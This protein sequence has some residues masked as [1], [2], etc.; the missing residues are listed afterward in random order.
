[1]AKEDAPSGLLSKMAKFVRN[2]STNW[3]DL[4]EKES[5]REN[6]AYTKQALKEMIERKRRNDF[7][8]KREFDMLRKLRRREALGVPGNSDASNRP[9]FFQSSMPSKPDDRAMTLKK[10]DEI[11]AQ[12]SMQ[13]WK[14]KHGNS[15]LPSTTA[16][17][18][19]GNTGDTEARAGATT[20]PPDATS[21]LAY[22]RTAPDDLTH[23]LAAAATKAKNAPVPAAAGSPLLAPS[24]LNAQGAAP[25]VVVAAAPLAFTP[26]PAPA[27]SAPQ[28]PAVRPAAPVPAPAPAAKAAPKGPVMGGLAA[29]YDGA[30][31]TGFSVSKLFALEVD[32]VQHDPELEEAA[33]RF[34]N[35]DDAGAE[36]GLLEVLSPQGQR[37]HHEET[38]CTVFDLY[39][40]TGQH[41]RFE[42]LAIDF[43]GKFSRSA[44]I[45]FSM[46][47]MVG[48]LASAAAPAIGRIGPGPKSDWRCPPNFGLQT[49]PALNA[50]L[51]KATQPWTL[52]WGPLKTLEPPAIVPL[53]KLFADWAK[54]PVKLRFMGAQV[55]EDLLRL[56]TPS[57]VREVNQ[58][59][60]QLRLE[61][62]RITHRPDE[63][64]LAAL[65][66]CVTYEVSPPSWEQAKCEY[67]SA[68]VNG[69]SGI[70]QTIIGEAVHDSVMS[71]F[72][73]SDDGHANSGM[74]ATQLS[75][76]ELSGQIQGDPVA[77]LEKLESRLEGADVMII[78]CAK[79]IRVDFSA[80]GTLLNWVSARQSEGRSVH[81][82]EVHRL[83]AAF[84]HVI[85]IS[86]HA[87]VTTRVN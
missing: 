63:F 9:S 26:S 70:G 36:A 79:L 2:P 66:F 87:K 62:L 64:E 46:P 55:I 73:G 67:K 80:A 1:M 35:G 49:L 59:L 19:G 85:G 68:D 21:N 23:A 57:G 42:S 50:A 13:W 4:D 54:Q 74:Q 34:A 69:V 78:S 75:A 5:D 30:S 41:D 53:T 39:R 27:A 76:V 37:Y 28:A 3:S 31:S 7:V 81:F 25:P 65:D 18:F 17:N 58:D 40:A 84:F 24:S 43:A 56:T 11:E 8:R 83:V 47:D 61:H 51:A 60:W 16:H 29:A 52:D 45:W 48:Q 82:T 6:S 22:A 72:S 32:E 44:P 33:I 86:E 15:G 10:I 12:M 77:T 38:W 71:E 20:T 14:T